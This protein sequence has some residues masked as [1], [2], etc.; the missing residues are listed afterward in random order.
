M[1]MRGRHPLRKKADFVPCEPSMVAS[2][3][4]DHQNPTRLSTVS[5]GL[6]PAAPSVSNLLSEAVWEIRVLLIVRCESSLLVLARGV[7]HILLYLALSSSCSR[8]LEGKGT[9]VTLVA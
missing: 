9:W 1:G 6:F 7:S 3:G 5:L 8:T 2:A 4:L